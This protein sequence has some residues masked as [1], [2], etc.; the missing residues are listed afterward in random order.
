MVGG[1]PRLAVA[2]GAERL[3]PEDRDAGLVEQDEVLAAQIG[4]VAGAE[5]G[6]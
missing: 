2:V 3:A 1:V 4:Q 5:T 6:L